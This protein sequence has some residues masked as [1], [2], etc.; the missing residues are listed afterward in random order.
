MI[1][2]SCWERYYHSPGR[3]QICVHCRTLDWVGF[4]RGDGPIYSCLWLYCCLQCCRC[5]RSFIFI[6]H[7]RRSHY[8]WRRSLRFLP[9]AGVGASREMVA[10]IAYELPLI[11]I[12]LTVEKKQPWMAVSP[13]R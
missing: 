5:D 13:S 7:S 1:S 8:H 2:L 9:Y 6:D 10:I 4:S 12:L 11:L 3:Y